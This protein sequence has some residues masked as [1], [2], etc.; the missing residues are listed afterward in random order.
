MM[1]KV[2]VDTDIIL[3]LLAKRDPHYQY[4]AKL[5]SLADEDEIKV[6]VSSL[7]FSNLNYILSKQFTAVQARKKLLTFK[8]LVNVLSVSEKSVDLALNSDFNDFED[9]LQYFTALEFKI[10]TLI[11]R[12]LKDYKKADI[13]V[14]TAEQFIKSM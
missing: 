1:L 4:S 10:S 6:Y 12:N 13:S 2:F 3:D 14:L 9:A 5:F 7:S 11:T 8:T